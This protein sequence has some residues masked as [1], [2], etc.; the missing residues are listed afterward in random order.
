MFDL[1]PSFV[2]LPPE[3]MDAT[4]R[5]RPPRYADFK[6]WRDVRENS[7]A[8]LEPWEPSWETDMLTR[9]GYRKRVR[10]M[11]QDWRD[12]R[13]YA[14]HIFENATQALVGGINLTGVRRR[15]AQY[16]SLGY[17]MGE[18]VSNKGLMSAA[19][20]LLLPAAFQEFGLH[21]VEAACIPENA[22]SRALLDKFG[23]RQVGLARQYLRINGSWRDH[24]L[25]ELQ[26]DDL[27]S[28]KGMLGDAAPRAR[29]VDR[30][31]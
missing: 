1:G 28:S 2:P 5:L 20:R 9:T 15:A 25:H 21:R 27:M 17:W 10:L 12:D 22:P 18:S 23:F 29:L 24:V 30:R 6:A 3:L 11:A 16:A 7:R 4:V 13:G 19:L 14:F 26:I 8:F 31:A